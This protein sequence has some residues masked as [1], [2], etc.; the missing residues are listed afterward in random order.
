MIAGR[1]HR[2]IAELVVAAARLIGTAEAGSEPNFKLVGY[3][4]RRGRCGERGIPRSY[5]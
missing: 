3:Y 5:C 4:Y 2:D 1:E